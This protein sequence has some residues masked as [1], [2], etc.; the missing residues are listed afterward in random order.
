MLHAASEGIAS[1][2]GMRASRIAYACARTSAL[3]LATAGSVVAPGVLSMD[4]RLINSILQ[5]EKHRRS[6]LSGGTASADRAAR[7]LVAR[8]ELRFP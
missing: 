7:I 6:S 8:R 3:R 1:S 4:S 2:R 5:E